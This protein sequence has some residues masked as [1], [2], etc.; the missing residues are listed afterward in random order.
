MKAIT[1]SKKSNDLKRDLD[2]IENYL[3][4]I[5][6][7]NL[8]NL[9]HGCSQC[10][11]CSGICQIS[12]V[13]TFTPSKIIQ[14]ILEGSE[15]KVIRSGVLW[16]CITCNSCLQNCPENVNFADIAR[17]AKYQMRKL[18]KEKID[19]ITA[20]R[21]IYLTLSEIMSKPFLTPKRNLD[22][23]PKDCKI[24]DNGEVL[25]FVGCLPFYEFEFELDNIA[26]STLKIM[27]QIEKDP[28]VVLK[29][30]NCCGHDLYW[31]QGKFKAFIRLAKKNLDNFERAGISKIVTA[32]AECYRTLSVDYPK[33]FEDF[34]EKFEVKHLIEYIYD[35]WIEGAIEFKKPK[36]N[37]PETEIKFTYHD[38]C[39]LSR[40]LPQES[41][42]IKKSREIFDYLRVLGYSFKEMKHNKENALCCGV[43]SWMN[44]NARSK[45]LRY[46]RLLEAKDAGDVMVTSCP[47]CNIHLS[48]LQNDYEDIAS[49]QIK[50]IS[51]FL[52][53][54]IFLK[55]VDEE[56]TE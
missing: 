31:G 14:L 46:T 7:P 15:D 30:E 37:D 4:K 26:K 43:S 40:F 11:K 24:S 41:T 47:K 10:S 9:L 35:K 18:D 5:L 17:N 1:E 51:E 49:I 27:C 55:K 8:R 42:V 48:C 21:G 36:E 28:V 38:P 33:L 52:V 29:D 53:S 56:G 20:H 2:D 50:D 44:C 25:Y 19:D 23:V 32:C 3:E 16:D 13:Q 12:K 34:N 39:R 45:A 6:E 54:L 22:W